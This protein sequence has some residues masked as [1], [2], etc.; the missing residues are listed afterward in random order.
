MEGRTVHIAIAL[1]ARDSPTF[2]LLFNQDLH[3][4]GNLTSLCCLSLKNRI[5]LASYI[6]FKMVYYF[7]SNLTDPPGF[8]YVGKDKYESRYTITTTLILSN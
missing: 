7:T 5:F 8:I 3:F 2:L 4:L 6:L 1:S